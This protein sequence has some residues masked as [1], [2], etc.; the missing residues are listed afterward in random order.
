MGDGS[1]WEM[2]LAKYAAK[3]EPSF[4][5]QLSINEFRYIRILYSQILISP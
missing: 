1:G 4:Q 3:T 5:M 2:Y